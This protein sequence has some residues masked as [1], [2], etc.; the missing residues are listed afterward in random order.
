MTTVTEPLP[1]APPTRNKSRVVPVAIGTTLAVFGALTALGAGIVF[2]VTGTDNSLDTGSHKVTTKTSALVS[3]TARIE[4]IS[5]VPG[6]LGHPRVKVSASSQAGEPPVFVGI[7]PKKAV[8]RYLKGASVDYVTDINVGPFDIE[9]N[10]HPGHVKPK[11]PASQSFWVAQSS[12]RKD[13]SVDWKVR[14]G[15][16]RVVVMNADGSKRVATDASF[17]LEVPHL[18]SIA[19]ATLILGLALTAGGIVLIARRPYTGAGATPA[20]E[21]RK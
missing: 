2:A 4:H 13:A 1:V 20:E 16:Y 21:P 6:F 14:N 12:G 3:P 8:D 17:G 19:A 9:R 15:N 11:P 5:D 18:S 7:G 10:T